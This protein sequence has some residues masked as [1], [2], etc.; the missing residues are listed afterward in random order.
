[1]DDTQ[2]ISGRS[3]FQAA[4]RAALA[5]AAAAGWRELF[6]CDPD[7]AAWPLGERVVVESLEQWI[8]ARH[9]LTIVARHFDDVPRRH[10]RW[11][12]WRSRWSHVAHC[13]ALP[14]L[15]ADDVPVMLLAP[16]ALVLNIADPLHYRGLLA[17]DAA[18]TRLAKE[19]L[20]AILQRSIEAFPVT[21]LGI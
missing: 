20:D 12:Q 10:P 1:M 18:S 11:V 6:L 2:A 15:S 13:R 7:F 3:E 16:G 19:R 5:E 17:R 21:T 9:Q 14:E 4:V 8:G